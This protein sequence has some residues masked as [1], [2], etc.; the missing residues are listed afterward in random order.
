VSDVGVA[1][2]LLRAGLHGARLNAEINTSSL[3]DA[4]YVGTVK[5]D[6]GRWRERGSQAADAA[7]LR[8]GE[9]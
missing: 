4:A 8:L 1:I 9:Q 7:D 6:V 5:V 3:S 2:G